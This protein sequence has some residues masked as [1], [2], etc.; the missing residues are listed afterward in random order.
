MEH[1]R[2]ALV[3]EDQAYGKALGMALL[4]AAHF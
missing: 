3:S 1:I 4:H 2:I